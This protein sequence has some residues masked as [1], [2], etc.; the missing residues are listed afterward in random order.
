MY[1]VLPVALFAIVATGPIQDNSFLWHVR[2]GS[3]QLA[4]SR[5]LTRDPFSY[6]VIGEPWRTQSWLAELLYAVLESAFGGVAWA[7]VLVG[8]VG[9]CTLGITGLT[10]FRNARSTFMTSVWLFI[11]VWLLAPFDQPRP[12][13][14]SYLLLALLVLVLSLREHLWWAIVPIVWVWAAVHGSWIIGVGLVILVAISRRSVRT[15]IVGGLALLATATTAHGLGAWGVIASFARN[16]EALGYMQEWQVPDFGDIAQAPYVLILFGLL[17]ASV[18]GKITLAE[19]W[20][21]LPFMAFGLTSHR[22]VPVAALVLLPIA[23]R[24][25]DFSPPV[26]ADRVKAIPWIVLFPIAALVVAAYSLSSKEL[27][28]ERFPSDV[29][30]D[31]AGPGRFFHDEAVGGYLIYRDGPGRGVYIDDRAEL[32]GVERLDEFGAAVDGDYVK[33]FNRL[34]MEAAIVKPEW[35]LRMT[36]LRDGWHVTYE[37]EYFAVLVSAGSDQ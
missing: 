9:V 37:D 14:F 35:P 8:V 21:V 36:L 1:P 19:L 22:A 7:T 17:V 34:S 33:L 2:A 27:Y 11:G 32:Y 29:A 20:V 26:G 15:G 10:I 13:I 23:A 30:I 12:V 6:M 4:F 3:V 28:P 24:S 31:A 16:S 25:I 18:R 5:V